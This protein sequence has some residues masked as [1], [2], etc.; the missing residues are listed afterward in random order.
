M[1]TF[2][3]FI[4]NTI[5]RGGSVNTLFEER[6]F[7]LIGTLEAIAAPLNSEKIPYELIGGGAVMVQVNR[8]EPSA[9]RNTKDLDIMIDRRDLDRIKEVAA[10]HGFT[11]RHSVG[12]DMLLP[13]GETQA[14]NAV[15]L[16]FSGEKVKP[17]Q[18]VANPPIRPEYLEI[19]GV[20][21]AVIPVR[22]LV[23]MKLSNNRDI[24]RVHVRDMDSVGL[25]TPEVEETLPHIL[26]ARLREIR[27][28][29]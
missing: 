2:E 12:V 3:R 6:L 9:V 14:R 17:N 18:V 1:L 4:R 19:H 27:S 29:E 5:E 15:H 22:D 25:I 24:D 8:V 20:E 10:E 11:F 21:V 16:I 26:I 7:A 23:Q 28:N 13:R